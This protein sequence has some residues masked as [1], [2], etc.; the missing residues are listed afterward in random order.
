MTKEH[1]KDFREKKQMTQKQFANFVGLSRE[2]TISDYERG[3]RTIPK[4]LIV[5]LQNNMN[6]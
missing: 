5:S 6:K 3:F 1:L 2:K 4:W